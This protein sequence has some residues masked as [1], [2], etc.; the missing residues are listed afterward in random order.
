MDVNT[1][2]YVPVATLRWNSLPIRL[3]YTLLT[4]RRAYIPFPADVVK[5]VWSWSVQLL[6]LSK[7]LLYLS[8]PLVAY[9]TTTTQVA[10]FQPAPF[11]R[12][13]P[14]TLIKSVSTLRLTS[15]KGDDGFTELGDETTT[16]P[17]TVVAPFL[18]QG[19]IAEEVLKVDLNDPKQTRVIIYIILSLVP[20]LFLIP[21]ML[22]SRDL[23]PVGALPP[24]TL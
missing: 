15:S 16:T 20:V 1:G 7:M 12:Y 19:D 18:S 22:G 23:I 14:A 8:L 24:V 5:L 13:L 4:Y 2:I 9:A 11:V 10:A 17:Q 21:L 3:S 6:S